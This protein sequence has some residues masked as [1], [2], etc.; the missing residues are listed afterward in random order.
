MQSL[1]TED[2]HSAVIRGRQRTALD[3]RRWVTLVEHVAVVGHLNL[4][5]VD[6]LHL[7]VDVLHGHATA[8][9]I[10]RERER[11]RKRER[12]R[13]GG[14]GQKTLILAGETVTS[15]CKSWKKRVNVNTIRSKV[16]L[17]K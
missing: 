17:V 5:V 6:M 11:E 7:K 4:D 12:E 9:E 3:L 2:L 1:L 16:K 10:E 8:R 13:G 15:L 14:G